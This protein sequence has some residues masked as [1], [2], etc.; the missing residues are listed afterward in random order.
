MKP[1]CLEFLGIYC[2]VVK[3]VYA[4]VSK[5]EVIRLGSCLAEAVF[6]GEGVAIDAG[7]VIGTFALS[8]RKEI[9]VFVWEALLKSE[10]SNEENADANH[11][12]F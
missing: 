2:P 1:A 8:T 4:T 5:C 3:R 10:E 9:V 12:L 7:L 6:A 11:A